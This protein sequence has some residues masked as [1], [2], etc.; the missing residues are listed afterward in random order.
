MCKVLTLFLNRGAIDDDG[1]GDSVVGVGVSVG[2][3][4]GERDDVVGTIEGVVDSVGVGVGR[5]E[6]AAA[7]SVRS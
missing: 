5:A 7:I 3:D 4:S 1:D 2:D 6:L